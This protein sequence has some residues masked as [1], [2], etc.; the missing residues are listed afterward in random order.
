MKWV[1]GLLI[2][3]FLSGCHL[4][5]GAGSTGGGNLVQDKINYCSGQ[6]NFDTCLRGEAWDH[7]NPEIC[8]PIV[9]GMIKL[10]CYAGITVRAIEAGNV[11]PGHTAPADGAWCVYLA[12]DPAYTDIDRVNCYNAYVDA[13]EASGDSSRC[14]SLPSHAIYGN[15]F[16]DRCNIAL[17]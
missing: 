4:F 17:S 16:Q 15:N 7:S 6:S 9:D 14:A 11:P 1:F 12:T 2:V 10:D 8:R 13:I 3:V 5:P